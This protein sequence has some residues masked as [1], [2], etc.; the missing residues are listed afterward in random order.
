MDCSKIKGYLLDSLLGEVLPKEAEE[1]LKEHLSACPRCRKAAEKLALAW[2]SLDGLEEVSFPADLTDK[3]LGRV[4]REPVFPVFFA[5]RP[6]Y[7][8]AAAVALI[9]AAGFAVALHFGGLS[10]EGED[11]VKDR[12]A[13]TF[14]R[15]Q[16]ALPDVSV[17]LD[18]YLEEA[19][20]LLV[21]FQRGSYPDWRE[22]LQAILKDDLPGQAN[23]LIE[24]I[25]E[26]SSSYRLVKE[27]HDSFWTIL[28]TGRGRED[29]RVALPQDVDVDYLLKEIDNFQK[30][31]VR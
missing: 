19:I 3:V 26:G 24:Q 4:E 8:W 15:E 29:E 16:P 11:L 22:A 5:R 2:K 18:S 1:M 17:I 7:G 12:S 27:L 25:P 31:K 14:S 21:G 6:A 23:Y 28:Q 20:D 30:N 9:V 13:N 10:R